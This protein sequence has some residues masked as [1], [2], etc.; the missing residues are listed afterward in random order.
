MQ[1]TEYFGACA[2]LE[3]AGKKQE[4]PVPVSS[5]VDVLTAIKTRQNILFFQPPIPQRKG[6]TDRSGEKTWC[7]WHC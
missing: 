4:E 5:G 2:E 7:G 3:P 1:V 6:E